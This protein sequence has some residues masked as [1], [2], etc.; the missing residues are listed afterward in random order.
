GV[1][2]DVRPHNRPL[3]ERREAER[4]LPRVLLLGVAIAGAFY[5][6]AHFMIV[7]GVWP[8]HGTAPG[9]G[10]LLMRDVASMVAWLLLLGVLRALGYRGNWAVV[11]LPIIIFFLSRPALFQLF[12]DPVYQATPGTRAE[13]NA[14]K[15]ERSQL[16]T[17]LRAY[18]EAEQQMV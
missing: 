11:A 12:T 8:V 4:G 7:E 16:T 5:L 6:L 9:A 3:V 1:A 18:D 10:G 14:L 13:A 15:A 2:I 17:I